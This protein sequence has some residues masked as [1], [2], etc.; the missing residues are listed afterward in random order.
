M[1]QKGLKP[2]QERPKISQYKKSILKSNWPWSLQERSAPASAATMILLILEQN[3]Y[4]WP[5]QKQVGKG[6]A[7]KLD[8]FSEK[9]QTAFD[10]PSFSKNYVPNFYYRYGCLNARR[11]DGQIV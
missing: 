2:N 10:P 3:V 5:Y 8:E 9:F 1:D 11:Y 6:R 4:P 7:T